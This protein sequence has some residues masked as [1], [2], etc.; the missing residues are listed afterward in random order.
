MTNLLSNAAKFSLKGEK[1]LIK[2]EKEASS[3]TIAVINKGIGISESSKSKIFEEFYQADSSDSRAKGGTGLGL[4]ICKNIVETM[5][6]SIGFESVENKET[7]FHF[8]FKQQNQLS[9]I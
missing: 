1:V 6:S 9:N 2:V 4:N 5:D 3:V 7:R 8:S